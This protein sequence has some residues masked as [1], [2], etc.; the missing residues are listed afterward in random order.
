MFWNV[1]IWRYFYSSIARQDLDLSFITSRLVVMSYPAEG[2]E[3]AYR[4]HI[5]DVKA[6]LDS[7]GY[8]F[9]VVN[10]SGRSYDSNKFGPNIKVIDGGSSWKDPRKPPS[11]KSVI[12][13]CDSI[14]K[15]TS[16]NTR[17]MVV[18]H[19]MVSLLFIS[20]V[21]QVIVVFG[22]LGWKI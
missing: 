3:S 11:M 16:Q 5:E 18:I 21:S 14:L 10:I 6:Y 9:I 8:P 20:K 1:L 17:N 7:R 2:L 12:S 19:C 4:N 13:L 15:W 22:F